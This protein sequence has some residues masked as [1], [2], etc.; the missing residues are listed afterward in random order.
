MTE[1][2]RTNQEPDK[3]ADGGGLTRRQ[4]LGIGAAVAGAAAAAPLIS[5]STQAAAAPVYP[6][7]P[8][9]TTLAQTLL[10]GPPGAKGYRHVV[11]GPGEPSLVRGD[12]LGGA[13]Y[14][15]GNR[16]PLLAISQLTDMH[17]VDAQSPARVEFLDRLKN[18]GSPGA[19]S[20]PLDAAYRP[21]E[22]LTAHVAESMVQALNS[23]AGAPV[24]G[25]P[26]DFAIST[27]D[28]V[29]N[30][31]YNELRWQIDILDGGHSVRPDSGDLTKWQGVGGSDDYDAAYWHPN[32]TPFLGKTDDYRGTWGYPTVPGLHNKCRAPF[33]STGLRTPWYTVFGNHDG[34]VQGNVPSLG[35]LDLVAKGSLKVTGLPT[36]VDTNA[37]IADF[38]AGDPNAL[39]VLLTAGP[40][41]KVKSDKNRHLMTHNQ[42]IRE[43]FTTTG[44]PVGHGYTQSNVDHDNAYYTF[45]PTSNV[46]CISLDTCNRLGYS[47][48]SLDQEQ[49]NWLERDLIAHSSRYLDKNGAWVATTNGDKLMVIFSHH[50][51]ATMNNPLGVLTKMG[52]DVANLLL[53][54]PNVVLWVNGHT[55]RNTVVPHSRAATAPVGGGFWEVNTAAHIDWPQQ[56][57]TVEMVSNGDGTL[58]IFGTIIDHVA[59]MTWPTDP[60]SPVDLAALSR[61]LGINDPQRDAETAAQDGRRGALSDRNVELLVKAPFPV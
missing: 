31:Q 58:S 8:A 38:V 17:I 10:H 24:T 53:R 3:A 39:A 55:H 19:S 15:P 22:M 12:L 5:G 4:V 41:K 46:H 1:D 2:P 60:T 30:T 20:L 34:L 37:L 54:F 49:F 33:T 42:M 14:N 45:D 21:Q 25:R 43:H 57:R 29:D 56:A 59:P 18:P 7:A 28:N 48:G 16:T 26:V 44:T 40:A 51:V 27:G 13:V 35:V 32:G 47:E 52:T 61:E 50:T 6:V 36:G 9:G 23:L 11:P